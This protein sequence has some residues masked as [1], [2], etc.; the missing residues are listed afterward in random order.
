[1]NICWGVSVDALHPSTMEDYE[2]DIAFQFCFKKII[3]NRAFS[4]SNSIATRV[5]SK[6]M[7]LCILATEPPIGFRALQALTLLFTDYSACTSFKQKYAYLKHCH[8]DLRVSFISAQ[9]LR[10]EIN[11]EMKHFTYPS[12]VFA[13]I[14]VWKYNR[15]SE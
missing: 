12:F 13:R 1:M 14:L 11:G 2:N 3:F 10:C 5:L 7:F 8:G 9:E 4:K 15:L 6:S